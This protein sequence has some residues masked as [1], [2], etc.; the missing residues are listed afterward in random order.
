M[1]R[2]PKPLDVKSLKELEKRLG[3]DVVVETRRTLAHMF[4]YHS[5]DFDQRIVRKMPYS[6][7]RYES[8]LTKH[9][10][11]FTRLTFVVLKYGVDPESFVRH[12]LSEF[13]ARTPEQAAT[14]EC[15]RSYASAV[16]RNA[17]YDDIYDKYSRT[18]E[19]LARMCLELG[20]GPKELVADMVLKNRLAYEYISGRVSKYFLAAISNFEAVYDRL[21]KMNKDELSIICNALDELRVMVNEAVFRKTGK[22]PRPM[23]DVQA[24]INRLT[25]NN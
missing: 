16:Y 20:I 10:K 15:F 13:G 19:S 8:F 25:T 11:T 5:Q 2:H 9:S 12:A 23:R 22:Y 14:A 6:S 3:A 18:V 4:K 1:Q 24:E 17:K 21:D 7:V